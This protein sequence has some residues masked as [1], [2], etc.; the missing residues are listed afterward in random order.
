M[1]KNKL[2]MILMWSITLVAL[3]GIFFIEPISQ[4]LGYH[5]FIDDKE[6]LGIPHF[7]NVMSN[8]PFLIVGVMAL[9]QFKK[10]NIIAEMGVA[11]WLLFFGIALVAFG[12]GYYHLNPDNHTLVW[13]R[14]P[15]TIAFMSLFAI[16][17]SEF[18]N[19]RLGGVLLFPLILVGIASVLYWQWTEVNG[20]GDL[21]IY[22]LV[23]FL[24]ILLIPIILLM[25]SPKYSHISGYWWLLL[26]YVAA[27][28]LEYYD[29]Q[30][31]ELL[32]GF[33]SGHSI[34]HV[35]AALGTYILFLSY[36]KRSSTE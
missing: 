16:I 30:V 8:V 17:I 35:A 22:A 6:M 21:R 20:V 3:I 5:N 23:Q 12:S 4:D 32:G 29:S 11:Y 18:I 28:A 33:I 15:M 25:Y 10:L 19:A 24:P 1:K 31:F 9:M 13:D 2:T 36:K 27:K 7:W 34:K 14:L 26:F